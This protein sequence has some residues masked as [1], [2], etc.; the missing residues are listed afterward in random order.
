MRKEIY[1]MSDA[2]AWGVLE[3]ARAV[4]VAVA[5]PEGVILRTLHAAVR[6]PVLYFHG[7]P[8]GEKED[9]MGAAAVVSAEE[10]F[11]TIPSYFIDEERACPATTF[12]KSAQVHGC[13][14]PVTS[15]DEKEHA[16]TLLLDRFQPEGGF[17]PLSDPRYAKAL[18]ALR[19]FRITAGRID[20]KG[21]F[22]QN[23]RPEERTRVLTGLW[24]RGAPGD[25]ET[26]EEVIRR[27]PGTPLPSLL[28]GPQ[29]TRL[30]PAVPRQDAQAAA[31][32][33]EGAYWIRS[34]RTGIA[35]AHEG[36]SAWVG[37][38]ADG[39]LVGSARALS[40]GVRMAWVLDVIVHPTRRG[41]GIGKALMKL[42][43]DHPLLRTVERVRLGTRDAAGLYAKFGFTPLSEVKRSYPVTEMIRT[44]PDFGAAF[45]T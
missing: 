40:D 42:L 41:Q 10:V 34:D 7:A 39:E 1:R 17:V 20:G 38:Y 16:L 23:R 14:Q 15:R 6:S 27:N 45:E 26:M 8:V 22:G 2:D 4:H 30:S 25:V 3:R 11:A 12:Y 32:L 37:A 44:M 21:K 29:G 9:M 36:A 19:V 33:L 35:R 13:V 31:S 28:H 24:K 18:D 43:L 5:T